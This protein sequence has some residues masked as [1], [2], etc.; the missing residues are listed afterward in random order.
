LT[1]LALLCGTAWVSAE[2]RFITVA[3]TTTSTEESG[4]F[5]HLLPAF[6]KA[7]GIRVRVVAP[8]APARPSI[9]VLVGPRDDPAGVA[10]RDILDAFRR[11]AAAR[12]P[13][14]SRGDRSGTHAAELRYWTL[15]GI[16]L[17]KQKGPWYRAS[18]SGMGA[19]LNIAAA[20]NAYLLC[21]RGSC[22]NFKNRGTLAV[23]VE[24]DRRLFNQ[25]G[26]MLVNPARHP[27][28]KQ[29]EGQAFIDWLVSPEGQSTIAAYRIGS[30][31]VDRQA[32]RLADEVLFLENGR[33]V[34]QTT[35]A[36]FVSHAARRHGLSSRM[37]W[38]ES[39]LSIRPGNHRFVN[40]GKPK[41]MSSPFLP[42]RVCRFQ[43][44]GGVAGT[45]WF[46]V[47]DYIK[48]NR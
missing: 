45:A 5:R 34:E 22:L 41:R 27:H 21:D 31:E 14:V 10:G 40:T 29:N 47:G 43:V 19:A 26:V 4:L 3:S 6:E 38:G 33:L 35:A 46:T 32:R 42:S 7:S 37:R 23:L 13:F 25:Y 1:C 20:L 11:I 28:V 15:A 12:A 48:L 2:E 8:S 30:A 9:L 44:A 18:G 39:R 36:E 24:G 17:E 16:D